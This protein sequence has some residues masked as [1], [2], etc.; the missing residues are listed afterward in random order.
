M[1]AA[2]PVPRRYGTQGECVSELVASHVRTTCSLREST[3]LL[4]SFECKH[5][6][7]AVMEDAVKEAQRTEQLLSA[8]QAAAHMLRYVLEPAA[9]GVDDEAVLRGGGGAGGGAHAADG[10]GGAVRWAVVVRLVGLGR[11]GRLG[12]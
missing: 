11:L 4:D 2:R 12:C 5:H 10:A 9:A 1:A 6:A 3:A 8:Y 7:H